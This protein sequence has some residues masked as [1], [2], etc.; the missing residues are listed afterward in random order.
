VNKKTN[1]DQPDAIF[2]TVTPTSV[3]GY[4][5]PFILVH[6]PYMKESPYNDNVSNPLLNCNWVGV[7]GQVFDIFEQPL[8]G[9]Y[10][11]LSG[12]IDGIEIKQQTMQSGDAN[13]LGEAGFEFFIADK[14]YTSQYALWLQIV[15]EYGEPLSAKAHFNTSVHCTQN[16]IQIDFIKVK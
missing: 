16:L 7:A 6:E 5:Y 4:L 8:E 15:D 3:T 2:R 13:L 14:P 12:S 11:R 1:L 9:V 10:I